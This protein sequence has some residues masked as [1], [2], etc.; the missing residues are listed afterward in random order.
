M[1]LCSSGFVGFTS[2]RTGVRWA[3]LGLLGSLALALGVVGFIQ[4]CWVHSRAPRGLLDSCGVVG[5]TRVRP[6]GRLVQLWLLGSLARALGVV[7]FSSVYSR[8][9][10]W[11]LSFSGVVGFTHARPGSRFFH[12]GMP[13]LLLSSSGGRWVQSRA[14][15]GLLVSSG[16]GGF[17]R[18]CPVGCWAHSGSLGSLACILGVIQGGCVRSCVPLWSLGSYGVFGFR[19]MG[20]LGCVL[21]VVGFIAGRWACFGALWGFIPGR[22]VSS[23]AA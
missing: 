10:L 15:W 19:W 9:P 5:F 14:L 8:A 2:V 23:S 22:W 21:E 6:W 7:G 18:A 1:S 16:E 4:G 20:S 11:S 13:L 12:S 3:N 17:T